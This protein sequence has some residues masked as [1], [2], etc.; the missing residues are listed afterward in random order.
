VPGDH[1][2]QRLSGIST[3]WTVLRAA[4]AESPASARAAQE[5]LVRRYGGAVY[6]YLLRAVGDPAGAEDLTQEFALRL[7]RGDFRHADPQ[8]GR[9][10]NYVKTALFHLVA[11][12]RDRL[13][14]LPRQLPEDEATA[15]V[16]APAESDAQFDAD[17]RDEVLSRAWSALAAE[18][19]ALDAALRLR[20]AN[21]D[22]SSPE[23]ATELS[24]QLGKPVSAEAGRQLLHRARVKFGE[25]LIAET[26][27]SLDAPSAEAMADELQD[28]G[29]LDYCRTA[30]R[31]YA[32]Q[33][34]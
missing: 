20:A 7:V 2:D 6:R 3:A 8:R 1:L 9:F 18:H 27:H 23:L 12:H 28:L 32:R 17:W 15:Q 13:R 4:H 29:L 34:D 26:A 5:E 16:P 19:P 11:Q 31:R 33:R 25:L 10:R 30:L 24:R 14:K 21:P 22:L